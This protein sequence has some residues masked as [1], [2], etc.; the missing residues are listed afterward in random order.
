M[1]LDHHVAGADLMRDKPAETAVTRHQITLRVAL[2]DVIFGVILVLLAAGLWIGAGYIEG[3]SRG[4]MGPAAF[5]RGIALILGATSLLMA[6]GG[7][8]GLCSASRG[9]IAT[10]EQPIPVLAS[11]ALVVVYP[12]LLGYFGYYLATGPWILALM[13]AAGCRKPLLMLLCASGFLIFTKAVFQ[14]LIGIPLP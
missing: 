8:V 12:I 4:L 11:L 5:P 1:N 2:L 10:V 6:I 3:N 9:Q 7:V 13:F 14:M